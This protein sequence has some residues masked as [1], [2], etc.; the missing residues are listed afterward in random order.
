MYCARKV[1]YSSGKQLSQ[2]CDKWLSTQQETVGNEII[3]LSPY[4]RTEKIKK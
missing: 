2:L 1:T 4:P 3:L